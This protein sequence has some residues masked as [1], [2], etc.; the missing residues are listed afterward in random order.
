MTNQRCSSFL[1][2]STLTI[3]HQVSKAI[4]NRTRLDEH[5]YRK[6]FD[7]A[8]FYWVPARFLKQI[9]KQFLR[10]LYEFT[11]IG[12]WFKSH[13]NEKNDLY[14][15]NCK[16]IY[17]LKNDISVEEKIYLANSLFWLLRIRYTN[18]VNNWYIE[19]YNVIESF[20]AFWLADIQKFSHIHL[21]VA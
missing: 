12:N 21:H 7:I 3:A 8:N 10:P 2:N 9:L 19:I 13:R 6:I 14:Y 1:W 17:N 4:C 20:L 18:V 11:D 15:F 16:L 5:G